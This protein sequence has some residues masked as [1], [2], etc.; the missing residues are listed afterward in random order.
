MPPRKPPPTL[1]QPA[2]R[3]RSGRY[4]VEVRDARGVSLLLTSVDWTDTERNVAMRVIMRLVGRTTDIP[5]LA[6]PTPSPRKN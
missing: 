5:D 4:V 6:K 3:K 2:P 1:E